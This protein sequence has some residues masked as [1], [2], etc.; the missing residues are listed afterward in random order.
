MAQLFSI[1][2]NLFRWLIY[3]LIVLIQF[4]II[5]ALG[6]LVGII[7]ALPWALR[8]GAIIVWFYGGYRFAMIVGDVYAPFSPKIPVMV[9][10]FF[11]VF[12]QLGAFLMLLLISGGG[13][14]VW[15]IL[16]FTGGIPL[17]L[18]LKGIPRAFDNWQNAHFIFS[19]MPPA[20]WAMMLIY[21][22]LK[23]RA[24]KAGKTF[25]PSKMPDF[26]SSAA[27]KFDTKPAAPPPLVSVSNMIS[28]DDF[29]FDGEE[30]TQS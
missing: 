18:A 22:T 6:I 3:A 1:I 23:G 5:V 4:L 29:A 17:W 11:V 10:Q 15:G 9:L 24:R 12:V 7:Y 30:V 21:L 14:L 8:I 2:A 20:L 25:S 16:Y 13:Q 27:K 19:V 28:F 26:L